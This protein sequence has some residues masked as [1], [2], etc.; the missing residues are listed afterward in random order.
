MKKR[1]TV[2]FGAETFPEVEDAVLRG[3]LMGELKE[4]KSDSLDPSL[5]LL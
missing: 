3:G 4:A 1:F 5:F 2:V